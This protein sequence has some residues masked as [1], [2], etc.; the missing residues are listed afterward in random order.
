MIPLSVA[1][2]P[3]SALD[4]SLRSGLS[5]GVP[6]SLLPHNIDPPWTSTLCGRTHVMPTA[7]VRAGKNGQPEVLTVMSRWT[8]EF[9]WLIHG[10]E[11][12]RTGSEPGKIQSLVSKLTDAELLLLSGATSFWQVVHSQVVKETATTIEVCKI[13]Q[14]DAGAAEGWTDHR[15]RMD[16]PHVWLKDYAVENGNIA[17]ANFD[18]VRLPDMARD[19]LARRVSG[20][21]SSLTATTESLPKGEIE[22]GIDADAKAA[23]LRE[24]YEEALVPAADVDIVGHLVQKNKKTTWL[25]CWLRESSPFFKESRWSAGV[26]NAEAVSAQWRP[27]E[28]YRNN[29]SSPIAREVVDA[30]NSMIRSGGAAAAA[31]RTVR[32]AAAATAATA[33]PKEKNPCRF[34]S[35]PKGCR[36]GDECRFSHGVVAGTPTS[37]S[38]WR[39]HQSKSTGKKYYFNKVTGVSVYE[40]PPDI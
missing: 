15:G 2:R 16:V 3:S 26:C 39:E 33:S 21:R 13:L 10:L 32:A 30:V 19:E 37:A 6:C 36:D 22:A 34:F 40:P 17:A 38:P 18:H 12:A 4:V 28:T 8:R 29:K 25:L 7:Q 23:A 27:W 20:Q 14:H 24:L 11:G 35:T 9:S 5:V 31:P 1:A